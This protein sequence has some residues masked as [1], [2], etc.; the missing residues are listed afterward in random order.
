MVAPSCLP[1]PACGIG[2][3]SLRPMIPQAV[4]GAATFIVPMLVHAMPTTSL[5]HLKWC[6]ARLLHVS[7]GHPS[8]T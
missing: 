3:F 6:L 5:N 4:A 2:L 7:N 8:C 1:G